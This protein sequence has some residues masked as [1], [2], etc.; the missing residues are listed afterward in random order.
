MTL[1]FTDHLMK[2]FRGWYNIIRVSLLF[3]VI[4][5]STMKGDYNDSVGAKLPI[6]FTLPPSIIIRG[7]GAIIHLVDHNNEDLLFIY[8]APDLI[9]ER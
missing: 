6:L 7:I 2:G 4:N 9:V 8:Y 1:L 3:V 5:W